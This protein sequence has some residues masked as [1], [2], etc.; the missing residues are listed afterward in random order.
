M[1]EYVATVI[2]VYDGDTITVQIDLGFSIHIVEKI[3]LA[4]VNAPELKGETKDEGVRSRDWL[5]SQL[6]LRD[7]VIRTDKDKKGKYGRY[8]G[9]IIVDGTNINDELVKQ[10]FAVYKDY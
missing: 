8:I 3:R 7:I 5:K 9:E 4:R 6:Y 1:Y 2:D 10:G